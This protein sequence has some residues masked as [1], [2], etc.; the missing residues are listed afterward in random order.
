MIL[1]LTIKKKLKQRQESGEYN[2][3]ETDDPETIEAMPLPKEEEKKTDAFIGSTEPMKSMGSTTNIKSENISSKTA[4]TPVA[5]T[6]KS[7]TVAILLALFLG[8]L[9]AH[10]FYLGDY[11]SGLIYLLFSWTGIP[12][13]LGVVDAIKY[14]GKSDEDFQLEVRY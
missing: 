1:E 2:D 13:F 7:K 11:R 3:S 8:G 9:G 14:I 6:N 5:R 10:K 12:L 4:F